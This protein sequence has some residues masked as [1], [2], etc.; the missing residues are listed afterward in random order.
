MSRKGRRSATQQE[1]CRTAVAKPWHDELGMTGLP[2]NRT[3]VGKPRH[4]EGVCGDASIVPAGHPA[5]RRSSVLAE[6][7]LWH[8]PHD[9][10]IFWPAGV[11][12]RQAAGDPDVRSDPLPRSSWR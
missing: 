9:R 7:R 5:I 1:A 6:R 4:A 11:T 2:A 12:P 10:R 3:T 8:L